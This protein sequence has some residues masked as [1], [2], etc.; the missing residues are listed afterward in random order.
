MNSRSKTQR[1]SSIPLLCLFLPSVAIAFF[2]HKSDVWLVSAMAAAG[3]TVACLLTF[4]ARN[5]QDLLT[6]IVGSL[7][8][9]AMLMACACIPVVGWIADVFILLFALASIVASISA[10]TPYALKGVAIWAVFLAAMSPPIFHPII[11]PALIFLLSLGL[12]SALA[13]KSSPADEFI[14]LI[15]SIP[16]LALAIAS[17][18]KLLQSGLVIRNAQFRQNVSGYTT[19]SGVQ[20]ADYTR[21]ITKAVPV[22]QTSVN[23][24]AAAIGGASGQTTP[25][26]ADITEK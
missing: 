18:G 8:F 15:S 11:S 20:V 5:W 10:L 17:L 16:L 1:F 13:K 22:V 4:I 23:P 14:L 21:T 3:I 9:I 12:G 19:R 25:D 7:L 24:V 6:G 2:C 26:K